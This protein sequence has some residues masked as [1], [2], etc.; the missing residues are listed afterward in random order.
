MRAS[1][2]RN[3]SIIYR[4]DVPVPVPSSGQVLIRV[5][6]CG[7]CG[8]DLHFATHSDTMVELAGQMVGARSPA[9]PH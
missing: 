1:V 9:S 6:A 8:G 2:L 5:D 4:D 3:G 7:V